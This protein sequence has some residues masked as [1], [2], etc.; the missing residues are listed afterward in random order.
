MIKAVFFDAIG[1]IMTL[2]I[3]ESKKHK[4]LAKENGQSI[5]DFI[6]SYDRRE[7]ALYPETI[8]VIDK[9]RA[10]GLKI[11]LISNFDNKLYSIIDDLGIKDKFDLMISSEDAGA[12]KPNPKI[13]QAALKELDLL[14]EEA[15][16]I[17]DSYEGDYDAPKRLGMEAVF[18]DRNQDDLSIIL[19][20]IK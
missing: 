12:A 18:L 8:E 13:Y 3:I 10:Q 20:S 7:W 11:A 4:D 16:M 14:P 9:L 5:H 19:Q 6:V 1:T 15:I 17:G 2:E